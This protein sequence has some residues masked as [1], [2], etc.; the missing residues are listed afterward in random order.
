MARE[1][2]EKQ[3]AFAIAYIETG[4]SV[5][6]YRR[7]YDVKKM[8]SNAIGVETHKLLNDPRITLFLQEKRQKSQQRHDVTVESLTL[9]AKEAYEKAQKDEK[10]APAMVQAAAFMGK[11]HGLIIDKTQKVAKNEKA[12]LSDAELAAI[13]KPSGNGTS[14]PEEV[15]ERP[16]I[17]H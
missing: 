7:A 11:L 8:S 10:G 4:N 1:L 6:A 14:Q 3:K 9:M 17:V 16:S 13:A 12:D 15:E 2:T 5:E